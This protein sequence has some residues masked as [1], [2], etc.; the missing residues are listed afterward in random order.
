MPLLNPSDPFPS[1][2]ITPVDG[3]PIDLPD[4]LAG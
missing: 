2:T 3:D 1:I 4:I